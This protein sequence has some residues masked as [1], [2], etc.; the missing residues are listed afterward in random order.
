MSMMR[1][2]HDVLD[3]LVARGDCTFGRS[4]GLPVLPEGLKLPADLAMFYARFGE[5]R[6]F[7]RASDSGRISNPLYHFLPPNAFVQI[8][9]AIIGEE[10]PEP[11]QRS[12]Y[13]LAHVQDGNYLAIDCYPRRLGYCYDAF[14][15]TVCDPSYC[16]VIARSFTE[17][18]NVAA[19]E[20][21]RAW[22]LTRERYGYANALGGSG[23]F[24]PPRG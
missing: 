15:E 9:L 14:H 17:L 21:N 13:A 20:E 3:G 24:E 4:R 10:T 11:L 6:L 22:W 12:W 2:L 19:E 16:K 1:P 8:G 5:A 18:M 23:A 7:G